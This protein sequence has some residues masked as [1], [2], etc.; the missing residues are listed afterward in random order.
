VLAPLLNDSYAAVRYI[1]GRSLRTLPGFADL[2]YD[3]VA[4][5]PARSKASEEAAKKTPKQTLFDP[6]IIP[7]LL[8]EQNQRPLHLRE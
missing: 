5:G 8:R 4:E 6:K 7:A 3:Y 1:A 2:K